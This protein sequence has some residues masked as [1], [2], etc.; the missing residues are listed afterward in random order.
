MDRAT[1]ITSVTSGMH[2]GM[3]QAEVANGRVVATRPAPED[4]D[5]SPMIGAIADVV[6]HKSRVLHP[7]VRA[8][9]LERRHNSDR[10]GRGAE[11]FVQVTWDA[12]LDLIADELRRVKA[13]HGNTAIFAGGGWAS[14][15]R[16]HQPKAHFARLLNPFGG[17][18]AQTTNWSFGAASIIMPRVVGTLAPVIGPMTDWQSILDNTKLIV[19]F[20]GV[21]AKNSQ[22]NEGGVMRHRTG[23][24]LRRLGENG[25]EMVYLSPLRDDAATVADA[26]WVPIRPSTD[27]AAML[28]LCHT[29]V[30]E[31]LHDQTFIDAYC[32]GFERFRPYLLGETDGQPKDAD[33]AAGLTGVPAD[34]MR[35]LARRMASRRTMLNLSWSAQRTDNGEQPCWL[36]VVLAALL[37]QIGLPGGGFGIGYGAIDGL[38]QPRAHL[39]TPSLPVPANPVKFAIPVARITDMLLHPGE[40]FEFNGRKLAY[41]DIKLAFWC[42]G[43]PFHPNPNLNRLIESWRR[44]DT[45]IVHEPWWTP[46]ARHADIVLP[47][48]TPL[49]RND[50]GA[51][52][53][54]NG[55]FAMPRVI[56]PL[57]EARTDFEIFCGLADRLG[58]AAQQNEGRDEMAWLRHMYDAA[59]D[60]AG[61]PPFDEFWAAGRYEFAPPAGPHVLFAEFRADPVANRL[62][63]PSGKIEIFSET[64]AAFDYADF[65]GHPAWFE[66][67]EWLGSAKTAQFPLHLI[68]N[69]PR[70]RLHSQMDMGPVS[71]AQKVAGREPV[72][73]H[74]VD[75]A[76]RG[77]A[78]GDVVRLFNQRG[79]CLAGARLSL[80]VMQGVVQLA[81]GAWYDP[82]EPG[83]IGTLDRHG[84]AN[85][86]TRDGVTSTL[87]QC[88]VAQS[89]LVQVERFVGDR[90]PVEAHAPPEMTTAASY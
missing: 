44:P 28:A 54:D 65:P 60:K 88:G 62:K 48:A 24:M 56:P 7:M 80:D 9:W 4:S 29:L 39:P 57:G 85:M 87:G 61:L 13:L 53:W 19:A 46:A 23:G 21:P 14:A 34:T 77:I 45:I 79:A 43:T 10:S 40:A 68:S 83:L 59:R 55:L 41:P 1:D 3:F 52:N 74:P 73:I 2:W 32:I 67:V 12:A 89:A 31:G 78:E 25:I 82:D 58:L 15:G 51:S 69:Q 75:A 6:H 90:R 16:F 37:G 22:M 84:N 72:T 71:Q 42:G 8:G 11:R 76:A 5:P 27:A 36:I 66:P 26:T 18:V 17:F 70:T 20:G 49:E 33:W 63:T 64:I 30:T 50:I 38:G 86:L 81:T 35:T 47:V